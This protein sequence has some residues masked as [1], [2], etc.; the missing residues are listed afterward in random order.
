MSRLAGQATAAAL[1]FTLAGCMVGPIYRVPDIATAPA[2]RAAPPTAAAGA[3]RPPDWWRTFHDP[4]LD[5]LESRALA[6]NLDLAAAAARV[7]QAR[8][9]AKAASAALLPAAQADGQAARAYS[10]VAGTN[11][12]LAHAPGYSRTGSLYDLTAGAS[13]ELDIFGG[14]RRD[15][16]AARAD[17]A[18]AGADL[19]GARLMLTADVADAYI[20]LRAFQ[21]RLILARSQIDADRR[22]LDL[23]R[24]R[25]QEGQAARREV[26]IAE[27]SLGQAQAVEPLLAVGLEAQLNRLAVLTGVS[28]EAGRSA[29]A[30][31][32]P[33][34]L[35]PD[36]EPGPPGA[37]LRTRPDLAAAERRLAAADARIGS[38]ISGYYPKVSLQSL[39]G[40]ESTSA[41]TLIT[42]PAAEAQGALGIKWRLFDFGRVDAEVANARGA[43]AAALAA[44]RQGVLRACED[45]ENALTARLQQAG[46]AI[47]LRRTEAALQRTRQATGD[48]YEAGTV[49][50]LEVIDADRQLMATQDGAAQADAETARA[51][52]ALARALG[53]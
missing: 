46:R 17:L 4:G 48:A 6:Q 32:G 29:L 24:L 35:A 47:M 3:L 14:L 10:S 18:A 7:G 43:E 49:S 50:L 34:P 37:L 53:G 27:A 12:Y 2:F 25:F 15:A 13:W 28:P 30:A 11:A 23:V 26:D 22:L 19:A 9:A 31:P 20:Q 51:A 33:I 40:W 52:V 38:A 5:D 45:V 16:Q 44:Y 39:L 8:A 21:T 41:A 1:A 42:S 36:L